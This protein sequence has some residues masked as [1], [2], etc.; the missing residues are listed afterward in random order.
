M[1]TWEFVGKR[2][3]QKNLVVRKTLSRTAGSYGDTYI[4]DVESPEL[5]YT[6]E[7]E[8]GLDDTEVA[9]LE[10]LATAQ[11]GTTTVTDNAGDSYTGRIVALSFDRAKGSEL[12][13]ATLT[14]RSMADE[15]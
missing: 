1:A 14:L 12:W 15:A 8:V 13:Q 9:A 11:D 7:T 5:T 6:L 4:Y 3:I 10:A 2:S